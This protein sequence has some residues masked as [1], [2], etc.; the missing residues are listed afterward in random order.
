[1]KRVGILCLIGA[2]GFVLATDSFAQDGDETPEVPTVEEATSTETTSEETEAAPPPEDIDPEFNKRLG[3]MEEHVNTLKEQV[4]R[5]KATLQLL[6]E[7]V[8]QGGSAGARSTIFHVN[9][10]G[11]SYR[12]ESVAYYLDGQSI[13]AKAD[14][15]GSLDSAKE[16]KVWDG[17]IPP[18][19][20]NLTVNMVLKGNG[21]G[22]FNYVDGYTFKVQSSYAFTAD[23][24]QATT[25][26]VEINE[27]KGFG[28]G[29]AERPTVEY[30]LKTIVLV[31][32][33]EG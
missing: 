3:T 8:I 23:E 4:F 6:K 30:E 13:F 31:E 15:G 14:P 22:V 9:G 5:S 27:K 2:I 10:L 25:L 20:H 28:V 18:G 29:F 1:M 33:S 16:L 26:N 11:P 12:L 7:I 21:F 19:S 24:G 17:A 32:D